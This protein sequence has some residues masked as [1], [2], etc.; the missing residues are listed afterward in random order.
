[1]TQENI[2]DPRSPGELARV[3]EA[4]NRVA[5]SMDEVTLR[6]PINAWMRRV[7][8]EEIRQAFPSGSRLLELG[9]GTAQDAV[10]LARAGCEIL[11][12]DLS[13]AMVD[14]ARKKVRALGLQDKVIV[15]CGRSRE[16]A[17]FA[18]ESPWSMF[19]GAYANFSLTYEESLRDV[20][21][22]VH[23]LVR[24]GGTFAFTL[25]SRVV[26]SE[27]LLYGLQ[28]RFAKMLWR[29]HVPLLKDVRGSILQIRAYVPGEVRAELRGLF[30]L[31]SLRGIPTFLPPVYL[32]A[33]Y[34]AL[35]DAG[36]ALKALDR[37]FAGRFP[38]NRLGEHTLYK[39]RR[40]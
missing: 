9:C 36:Q 24:P 7:N 6:N 23:G 13:E 34:A 8:M 12:L 29:L 39:F 15:V 32:H 4:F 25:P 37:R 21:S 16:A 27:L 2:E 31:E 33:Q 26:L 30:E 40:T 18:R 14:V 20:A 28:L 10:E 3:R 1:M 17:R 22:A 11:A 35:G 5:P 38:W 19:D